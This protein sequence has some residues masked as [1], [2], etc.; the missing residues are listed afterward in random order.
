MEMMADPSVATNM[1]KSQFMTMVPNI[2]MMMLINK[3]FSGFVVAQFPFS[4]SSR[5]RGMVQQG[6][7]IDDLSG[8]YVTSLSMF[9]IIMSG[10]EG[11]LS[12]LLGQ[13]VKNSTEHALMMQQMSAG[14]A[15]GAP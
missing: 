3:F 14:M 12:L 9:F 13:D 15:T 5:L 4:L 8:N 2:G 10:S 7:D 1:L 11:L 6:L